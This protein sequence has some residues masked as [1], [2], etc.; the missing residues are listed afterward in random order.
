MEIKLTPQQLKLLLFPDLTTE[1]DEARRFQVR[2]ILDYTDC[3]AIPTWL[4]LT[5]NEAESEIFHVQIIEEFR[6]LWPAEVWRKSRDRRSAV[7]DTARRA[8][9]ADMAAANNAI[10]KTRYQEACYRFVMDL[11]NRI[12]DNWYPHMKKGFLKQS[13]ERMLV[14][15]AW[16]M[17]KFRESLSECFQDEVINT[18][19]INEPEPEQEHDKPRSNEGVRSVDQVGTEERCV[20]TKD[21]QTAGANPEVGGANE[22]EDPCTGGAD[23]QAAGAESPTAGETQRVDLEDDASPTT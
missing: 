16:N 11:A 2:N 18:C 9:A 19:W 8:I 15:C 3:V 12:V 4:A 1:L 21:Q 22:Q 20:D 14:K 10:A 17:Q 5:I 23:S 13:F 6:Y 7:L